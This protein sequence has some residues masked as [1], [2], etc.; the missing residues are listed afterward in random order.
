MRIRH[1]LILIVFLQA[2]SAIGEAQPPAAD[3]PAANPGRPTVAAPATLTP[4]G[5]FQFETG[6]LGAWHS[7]QFSSQS[8]FNEAVKISVSRWI[9]LVALWEPFAHSNADSQA[10]NNPGG[11]AL[12]LQGVIHHGDGA[13]PTISVDY[14]RQVYG[15]SAPDLDIGSPSHSVV[16]LAS[17][18]VKGFHYDANFMVN[19]VN[20]DNVGRA[21]FGQALSVSHELAGRLGLTGEI[22]HLTQPFLQSNAVGI[23]WAINYNAKRNLVFDAGFNRGLTSTSTGWVVFAGFTYL[24]PHKIS[25][26]RTG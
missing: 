16:F 25:L 21:Q 4:A 18:D 10:S 17:A 3:L 7:P 14:L 20:Q 8:S 5:Y 1:L 13:R 26:R 11:M 19:E 23:L 9:E 2:S 12:G 24:L 6:Y 15:G 22:W